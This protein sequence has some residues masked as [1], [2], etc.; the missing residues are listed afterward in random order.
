MRARF[1]S[2]LWW[3]ILMNPVRK[4][5]CKVKAELVLY[6]PRLQVRYSQT[7]CSIQPHLSISDHTR[8]EWGQHWR[9]S[10]QSNFWRHFNLIY[11]SPLKVETKECDQFTRY[12]TEIQMYQASWKLAW[13]SE[14]FSYEQMLYNLVTPL[15]LVF[16][17]KPDP[18]CSDSQGIGSSMLFRNERNPWRTIPS[19]FPKTIAQSP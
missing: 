16:R 9:N 10:V 1:E 5:Y 8:Y 18:C 14:C 4:V 3:T 7:V 12:N 6:I 19:S 17:K 11:E 13:C 2:Y 15:P